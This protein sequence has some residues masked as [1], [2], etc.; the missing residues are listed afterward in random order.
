MKASAQLKREIAKSKRSSGERKFERHWSL[1]GE[2]ALAPECSFC[3]G[4]R[5]RLD[6]AHQA[7]KVAIEIEGGTWSGG[8]HTRGSGFEADCEK[9]NQAALLG[10]V[11]FRLTPGM[12]NIKRLGEIARFIQVRKLSH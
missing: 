7:S 6:F 8:R 1:L 3:P 12:I 9:Y 2:I 4:R 11:V 10:W 5:W